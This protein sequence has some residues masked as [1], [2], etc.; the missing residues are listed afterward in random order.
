MQ[1]SLLTQTLAS[2]KYGRTLV[3]RAWYFSKSPDTVCNLHNH[4]VGLLFVLSDLSFQVALIRG[5]AGPGP[6]V[7][8][9]ADMDA[10]AVTETADIPYKS[11][12]DGKMHACGHDG[13]MAGQ[14]AAA[15]VLFNQR[16][17]LRGT[18]KLIF[19]PAEEGL[20]GAPAMMKDGVLEEGPQGPR[21]DSIYGI[22]LWSFE[23]LG[24]IC[25]RD[26][27]VMAASD[28]FAISVKGKGGHG[29]APQG[30][31]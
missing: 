4:I 14:L 25:C 1:V 18:V 30:T 20:G 21:V 28:K 12:N 9:R 5:G 15:Q 13:H 29:A 17:S 27:P 7:A 26:G 3:S 8:L 24:N 22:H 11:Q 2:Q 16:G 23:K 10:L 31:V 6:C 19:Q